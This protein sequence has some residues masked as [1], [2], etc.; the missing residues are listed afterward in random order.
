MKKQLTYK[1]VLGRG[2]IIHFMDLDVH[3]IPAKVDS[4]AYR[5]TI[6]ARNV[7]VSPDGKTLSFEI[8]GGHPVYGQFAKTVTVNSFEKVTVENSFGHTEERYYV[9]LKVSIGGKVFKTGFTLGDR[10]NKPFPALLGRKLLNNRFLVD[11]SHTNVSR[12]EL[13]RALLDA[14]KEE[15]M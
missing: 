10:T 8:L 14:K 2:E 12:V 11:T 3:D 15:E 6:H 1:V 13:K 5:S 7:A 9:M 4:G